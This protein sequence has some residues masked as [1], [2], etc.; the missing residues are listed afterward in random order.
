[1]KVV[2]AQIAIRSERC[3][4]PGFCELVSYLT[5]RAELVHEQLNGAFEVITDKYER[6]E[7]PPNPLTSGV[8]YRFTTSGARVRHTWPLGD[9][10]RETAHAYGTE[11]SDCGCTKV[12]PIHIGDKQRSILWIWTCLKHSVSYTIA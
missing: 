1:M 12:R 9:G 2:D 7:L 6:P 5:S 4:R 8:F 11:I 10:A 3:P